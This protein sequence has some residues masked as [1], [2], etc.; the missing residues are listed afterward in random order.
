MKKYEISNAM[1]ERAKKV[2]PL[3]A[4]TFSKSSR[5]YSEGISPSFIS[6]GKG[7][8]VFDVDGN[9]FIDFVCA[10]GPITVGYNNRK[11]NNSI[12]KQLKK[13]IIFSQQTKVELELAEKLT[14][15]IKCAEM[16]RFV[17]NGSDATSSA[18]KLARAFTNRDKVVMSGYHG[19]QDWSVAGSNNRKGVPEIISKL[20]LTFEYNNIDS[21]KN[22]FE[23]FPNDIAAV[24]LE[25]I[26]KNGPNKRFL[27]ELK[28]LTHKFGALLIFDE[29]VSGFR[30]A[31][32]GASELYNVQPDLIAFGK[33][34]A[35]GMPISA[36]AGK[37][38]ILRLIEQGVFISTTFGGE[39]LSMAAALETLKI[40]EKK[41][42]FK[43]FWDLGNIMLSGLKSIV[44][45]YSLENV[46]VVSGLA[47][48]CGVLFND[49]GDLTYLDFGTIYSQVM[50]DNGILTTGIN[51]ISLSHKKKH[52]YKFLYSADKAMFAINQ[53][54]INNSTK[55]IIKGPKINPI[56]KRN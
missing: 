8:Y 26:Q 36:I 15:L 18:I 13:G 28:T 6:K 43:Y 52:I 44:K 38:E 47:P 37:S 29:V 34:M 2:T 20:T 10:L 12:L 53:A 35:N 4:Q 25:P 22:L 7:C 54:V 49:F 42:T 3:G 17:K 19:M 48:H 9:K 55:G 27:E 45:K 50:V 21:I 40:L 30:Y 32:G 23:K 16:I 33:G 14:K 24:I 56:F 46:V 39:A 11:I 5:Y 51:N 1:L 31:L 41:S